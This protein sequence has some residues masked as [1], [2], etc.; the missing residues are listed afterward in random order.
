MII[1]IVSI[2]IDYTL[3]EE[4]PLK[5]M[6]IIVIQAAIPTYW[7]VKN[8]LMKAYMMTVISKFFN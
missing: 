1:G 7:V 3:D 6:I 8:E 5:N 4:Y 2:I